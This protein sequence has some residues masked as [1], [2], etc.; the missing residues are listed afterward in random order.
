MELKE[1]VREVKDAVSIVDLISSYQIQIQRSGKYYKALCP[2]H[3]EKTPS[4]FIYP[5]KKRYHCFG[6]GATG[7][8]IKFVQEY[9]KITFIDALKELASRYG[10]SIQFLSDRTNPLKQLYVDTF[11]TLAKQYHLSLLHH[12]N[13]LKYLEDRG[14]GK[15]EAQQFQ[16]G[17]CDLRFPMKSFQ[18]WLK[19]I[20][21]EPENEQRWKEW[22]L[23]NQDGSSR[24]YRRIIFPIRDRYGACIGFSGRLL[25]RAEDQL[26]PTEKKDSGFDAPKYLNSP[27]TPF[28]NK[29]KVLYLEHVARKPI[30]EFGFA[31][32][33]E[34]FFDAIRLHANG[35][36]NTV[37]AMG[38]AFGAE[39]FRVLDRL[40]KQYLFIFDSDEAGKKAAERAFFSLP[41]EVRAMGCFLS[42]AKDPDE[43]LRRIG[44]DRFIQEMA[45]AKP[46]EEFLIDF[47]K[48]RFEIT[49][50]VGQDEYLRASLP[51]LTKVK[52]IGNL[53]SYEK[54]V[55]IVAETL[56][57]E[58]PKVE[59]WYREHI[60][61]T[62]TTKH[63]PEKTGSVPIEPREKTGTEKTETR[64]LS[65]GNRLSRWAGEENPAEE[66]ILAI[67]LERSSFRKEI[68]T[69]VQEHT[70]YLNDDFCSFFDKAR[71]EFEPDDA[72]NHLNEFF[73]KEF[74]HRVFRF[75]NR[76]FFI[77]DDP[78]R[79][80]KALGDCFGIIRA[81]RDV[82][83]MKNL[84][85]QI[86]DTT[87]LEEKKRLM[88][89]S[90]EL[91]G[92]SK[93]KSKIEGRPF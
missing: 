39:H 63:T 66:H 3:G 55:G 87:D 62:A 37:A 92:A 78:A 7:D 36:S 65:T 53:P 10:V 90:V 30:Q 54:V 68:E 1:I 61:K 49:Q 84:E 80:S 20:G 18:Q 69:F 19:G 71:K 35:I 5:E 32:V 41:S 14:Y 89:Q 27:Q 11:E 91:I 79:I 17:Y 12:P 88:K 93:K 43:Y 64:A 86:R 26:D 23:I 59:S 48:D 76:P 31:I 44:K 16:I 81:R 73:P 24:F 83:Q 4:F 21:S 56:G 9:E 33:V 82:S 52:E 47:L 40:T 13:A 29:S 46:L 42:E 6:C 8:A 38:T 28:F 72:T 50:S 75:M 67:Y 2:F 34:G 25:E 60:T 58:R 74:L 22:G 15:S 85:R 51:I 77:K 57:I 70:A 45:A